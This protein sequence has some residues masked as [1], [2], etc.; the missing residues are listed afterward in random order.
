[1]SERGQRPQQHSRHI[2]GVK[3]SRQ[4]RG[5]GTMQYQPA[6][7]AARRTQ[8]LL[9]LHAALCAGGSSC[10]ESGV[11]LEPA[12]LVALRERRVLPGTPPRVRKVPVQAAEAAAP[13]A[14]SAHTIATDQEGPLMP[15]GHAQPDD[16]QLFTKSDLAGL[17]AEAA[18]AAELTPAFRQHTAAEMGGVDAPF[19]A[20]PAEGFVM[21][22]AQ[23]QHFCM[24]GC[25]RI[26]PTHLTGIAVVTSPCLA[27]HCSLNY[28]T[29]AAAGTWCCGECTLRP[30]SPHCGARPS[31]H[32]GGCQPKPPAR[33]SES[34]TPTRPGPRRARATAGRT[35]RTHTGW[36][37]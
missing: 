34:I 29:A 20:R 2:V 30:R 19:G 10:C 33:H 15:L 22:D 11:G 5:A 21:T 12:A 17:A 27:M 18:A 26:T 37:R 9:H 3:Q 23:V 13:S 28:D 25:T 24:E 7:A 8:A 31:L 14:G 1:M 36:H 35:R 32:S 16:A 4:P 6:R